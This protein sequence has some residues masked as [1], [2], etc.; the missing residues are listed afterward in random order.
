MGIEATGKAPRYQFDHSRGGLTVVKP[1]R[2]KQCSITVVHR[3][4]DRDGSSN[5]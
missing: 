4:V 5:S 1:P 2:A 3:E